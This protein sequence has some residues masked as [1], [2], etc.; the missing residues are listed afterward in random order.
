MSALTSAVAADTLKVIVDHHHLRP[1]PALRHGPARPARTAAALTPNAQPYAAGSTAA[2]SGSVTARSPWPSCSP[3]TPPGTAPPAVRRPVLTQVHCH[4]HPVL[5]CDAD[6]KLLSAAGAQAEHLETGCC[7]LAGNFG[8]QVSHGEVSEPAPS[9]P[10]CP[11]CGKPRR[12]RWSSPTDSA[13]AP[14]STNSTAAAARPC[15]SPSCLSRRAAST[16]DH[17]ERTAAPAHP[18]RRAA[19][20]AG[21]AAALAGAAA[22]AGGAAAEARWALIRAGAAGEAAPVHQESAAYCAGGGTGMAVILI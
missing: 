5:G 2:C 4:Q 21:T 15:T 14:R 18:G 10:G 3:S 17:P 12:A 20:L 19:A 22:I 9:A 8:F 6:E 11:G 13:A 7:G 16:H 1:R